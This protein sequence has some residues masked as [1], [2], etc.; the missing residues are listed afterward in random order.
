M[1]P[2]SFGPLGADVVSLVER[3]ALG[4]WPEAEALQKKAM[5]QVVVLK[6]E[7]PQKDSPKMKKKINAAAVVGTY[8]P[9]FEEYQYLCLL[10]AYSSEDTGNRQ[11]YWYSSENFGM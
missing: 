3:N 5:N 7:N 6:E 4:K 9:R 10:P 1:E 8:L 11:R 2:A